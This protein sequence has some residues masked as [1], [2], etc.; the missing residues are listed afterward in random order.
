M[1]VA[2]NPDVISNMLDEECVLINISSNE[3][4]VL[5][6]TAAKIWELIDGKTSVSDIR[7]SLSSHYSGVQDL[8]YALEQTLDSF[9]SKQ[10]VN[11]A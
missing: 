5:N 3:M 10:L 6:P 1:I 8:P 2:R 9:I 7:K 11:Y 4:F